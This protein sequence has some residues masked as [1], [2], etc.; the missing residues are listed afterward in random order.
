MTSDAV[1]SFWLNLV[2]LLPHAF[3][4]P[5]IVPGRDATL[6]DLSSIYSEECGRIELLDGDY[7]HES[8]IE[9]PSEVMHEY[10]KYRPTPFRRAAGFEQAL[11]SRSPIFYKREDTN[12]AGSH[13]PNTAIPQAYYARKQGLNAL[14]TD[15]GA[16]QWGAALAW[17][18]RAQGLGCTVFMTRN[19]YRSKP[20]RSKPPARDW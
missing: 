4:M 5:R 2:P 11:K 16:G 3:P 6:G 15:T 20:Y 13:K 7:A 14:V 10:R 9:I 18:C 19:S 17:A 12:P 1:P 8:Q